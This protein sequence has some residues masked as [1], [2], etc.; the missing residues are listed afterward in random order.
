MRGRVSRNS[1][2]SRIAKQCELVTASNA[3]DKVAGIRLPES[4]KTKS[5]HRSTLR[6][7]TW[8]GAS[9]MLAEKYGRRSTESIHTMYPLLTRH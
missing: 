7:K 6:L 4:L 2:S 5:T 9:G 8:N 3:Q 1:K